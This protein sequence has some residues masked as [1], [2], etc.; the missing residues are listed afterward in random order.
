MIFATGGLE[1]G[2]TTTKS[3]PSSVASLKASLLVITPYFEPSEP[4]TNNSLKGILSL[5]NSSLSF[6]L[7][8]N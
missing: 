3:R 7:S 4:M 5:T 8:L 6:L 2:E 1:S